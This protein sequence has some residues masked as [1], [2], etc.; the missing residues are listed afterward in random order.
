MDIPPAAAAAD[1]RK[2][3]RLAQLHLLS[4]GSRFILRSF[5]DSYFPYFLHHSNKIVPKPGAQATIPA[6]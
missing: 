5:R 4:E 6:I 3:R 1:L 2:V